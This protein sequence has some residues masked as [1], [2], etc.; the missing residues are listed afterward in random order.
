[1]PYKDKN[2]ARE[3][4]R[5]WRVRNKDREL[6]Y[7]R[8]H[9]ER[10]RIRG[11][12]RAEAIRKERIRV[13]GEFCFFCKKKN[14]AGSPY[15]GYVL[16]EIHGRPHHNSNS[17]KEL[18][19]ALEHK[20]DFVPLCIVEHRLVHLLMKFWHLSWEEIVSLHDR[21][22]SKPQRLLVGQPSFNRGMKSFRQETA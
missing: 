15:L 19:Y 4:K 11:R 12:E 18:R 8:K 21:G 9:A 6:E 20:E 17:E 13:F 2:E 22:G 1:M 5:R 14:F 16:H 10:H 7:R 3:A